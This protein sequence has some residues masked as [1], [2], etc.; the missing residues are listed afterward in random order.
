MK[1]KNRLLAFIIF[2]STSSSGFADEIC[3]NIKENVP[4]IDKN[5]CPGE[6]CKLGE[7]T[8]DEKIAVFDKANGK[9]EIFQL[10]PNEKFSAIYSENHVIPVK[11]EVVE[12]SRLNSTYP[13]LNLKKGDSFL[14][15]TNKGEGMMSACINGKKLSVD[16]TAIANMEDTCKAQGKI[17]ARSISGHGPKATWWVKVQNSKGKEG[18][19]TGWGHKI[20]GQDKFE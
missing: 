16:C 3:K 8:A 13:S 15:F 7:W 14:L 10:K 2:C 1:N 4:I 9:K 6:G 19:I 5:A 18:W 12:P 17:S 11:I 20:R